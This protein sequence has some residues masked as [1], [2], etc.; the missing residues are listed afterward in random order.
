[1]LSKNLNR[2]RRLNAEEIHTLRKAIGI[3]YEAVRARARTGDGA[4]SSQAL[5]IEAAPYYEL[6]RLIAANTVI[7]VGPARP[8]PLKR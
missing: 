6:Y 3:A 2:R 5:A 7:T 8:K 4:A 1:M